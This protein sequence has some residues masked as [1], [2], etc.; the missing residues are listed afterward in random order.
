MTVSVFVIFFNIT[1]HIIVQN[2]DYHKKQKH[3]HDNEK[4]III[5]NIVGKI[6]CH[7][8]Y[9]FDTNEISMTY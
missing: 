5:F 3:N 8:C 9:L 1:K 6:K 7:I 4:V 2:S